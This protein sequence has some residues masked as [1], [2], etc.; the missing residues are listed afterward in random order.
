MKIAKYEVQTGKNLQK[1]VNPPFLSPLH[2]C[3][4]SLGPHFA[5]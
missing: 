4:F 3:K 2:F 5:F 1:K